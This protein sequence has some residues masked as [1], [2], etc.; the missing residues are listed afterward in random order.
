MV[1]GGRFTMTTSQLKKQNG[2]QPLVSIFTCVHKTRPNYLCKAVESILG[3]DYINWEYLIL[4]TCPQDTRKHIIEPY[5]SDSRI[6]YEVAPRK[7]MFY[8]GANFSIPRLK[9]KYIGCL[10]HDDVRYSDNIST[11]VSCMEEHIEYGFVGGGIDTDT[12]KELRNQLRKC[13]MYPQSDTD[14]RSVMLNGG[15]P[16][17]HSVML[18]RKDVIDLLAPNYYKAAYNLCPEN[19]LYFRLANKTR[20]HN[21]QKVLGLYRYYQGNNS[22]TQAQKQKQ[23]YR[24]LWSKF[25]DLI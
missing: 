7:M 11:I 13:I 8:E 15:T 14:I 23:Q 25:K 5:L 12:D 21:I 22:T 24:A 2:H 19:Q 20:F 6:K 10:D 17:L 1:G 4:D 3:Q 18:M 16:M 9:G